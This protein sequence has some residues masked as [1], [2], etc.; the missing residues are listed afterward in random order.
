MIEGVDEA[1]A[2]L[3]GRG[4][5]GLAQHQPRRI[6]GV[7]IRQQHI[8]HQRIELRRILRVGRAV[9]IQLRQHA[10]RGILHQLLRPQGIRNGGGGRLRLRSRA[11]AERRQ[12]E[13]HRVEPAGDSGSVHVDRVHFL[14]SVGAG[15]V[16]AGASVLED[17]EPDCPDPFAKFAKN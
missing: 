10:L 4:A 12:R 15:A 13:K 11:Q 1:L 5:P 7:E 9:G 8:G 3:G 16:A 2:L 6:F 17:A 14:F